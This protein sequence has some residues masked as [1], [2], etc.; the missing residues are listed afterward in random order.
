M[1]D[2]GLPALS[3]WLPPDAEGRA[4]VLALAD[5][6][7]RLGLDPAA[8]ILALHR[9][10]RPPPARSLPGPRDPPPDGEIALEPLP[11]AAGPA[12]WP[13]RPKRFPGELFSG[14]L[15]RVASGAGVPPRRLAAEALGTRA[16]E[17]VD[18]R[19]PA[20][21]VR[22]LAGLTGQPARHLLGGLLV[23]DA[24]VDEAPEALA[25]DMALRHGGCLLHLPPPP[26][27]RRAK[28]AAAVPVL[29]Y[30]PACFAGGGADAWFR[31]RWRS[32]FDAFCAEHGL[33][34]HDACWS[35]SGPVAPLADT[36][37]RAAPACHRCVAPLRGAPRERVPAGHV[38]RQE[39]LW[40]MLGFV[41]VAAPPIGRRR[42]TCGRWRPSDWRRRAPRWRSARGRSPASPSRAP[43]G[44]GPR[45][46]TGTHGPSC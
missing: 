29:Q 28:P 32:P 16:V 25:L 8:E 27:A 42:R 39:K 17:T 30:C 37:V 6:I 11:P 18:E 26:D 1:G 15:W 23:A 21:P 31:R 41:A 38:R 44:S 46:M 35:C 4:V 14:W 45:R 20:K 12:L 9:R 43:G 13:H 19:T 10:F 36:A 40:D 2:R 24:G 22:R 5:A 7:E 33:R 3:R 34:L